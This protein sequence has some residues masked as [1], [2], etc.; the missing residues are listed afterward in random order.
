MKTVICKKILITGA[1][2]GMGKLYAQLAV[3][4]GAGT[5][6]LWDINAA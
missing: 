3:N 4:E 6:V 5:I 1:A 2:M